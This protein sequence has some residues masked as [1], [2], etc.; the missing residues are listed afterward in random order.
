[1]REDSF[2]KGKKLKPL[3]ETLKEGHKKLESELGRVKTDAI[4]MQVDLYKYR[5]IK[6]V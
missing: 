1:M 2:T 6:F 3:E 5:S 4:S